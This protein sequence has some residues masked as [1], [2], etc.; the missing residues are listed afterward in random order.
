MVQGLADYPSTSPPQSST[1]QKYKKWRFNP[2]D[3]LKKIFR[4]EHKLSK[5][6]GRM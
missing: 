6:K 1:R 5:C 3:A 2:L 4:R